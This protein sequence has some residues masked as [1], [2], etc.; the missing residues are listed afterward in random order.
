[1]TTLQE[2]LEDTKNAI[3][4]HAIAMVISALSNLAI[5][6]LLVQH[7]KDKRFRHTPL[8][9]LSI[10]SVFLSIC[11]ALFQSF[12]LNNALFVLLNPP[13][14]FTHPIDNHCPSLAISVVLPLL[15]MYSKWIFQLYK[16]YVFFR[17]TPF[18]LS[19]IAFYSQGILFTVIVTICYY[20]L[21]ME[22]NVE[23]DL[24][25]AVD[26]AEYKL[27][28]ITPPQGT[29]ANINTFVSFA[30][31]SF[32]QIFLLYLLYSKARQLEIYQ[33][34]NIELS[35]FFS[36]AD[37]DLVDLRIIKQCLYG[38]V[39]VLFMGYVFCFSYAHYGIKYLLSLAPGE[40][41]AL[42]VICSFDI[43]FHFCGRTSDE[44]TIQARNETIQMQ[45]RQE[46]LRRIM[47]EYY[48]IPERR[49]TR[50][51]MIAINSSEATIN[52][53]VAIA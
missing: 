18:K 51:E 45:R 25:V 17:L 8:K 12:V 50:Q 30:Y 2:E 16:I 46:Y 36:R 24:Y 42:S 27:C 39:I 19:S 44:D 26:N 14:S 33:Q 28:F 3:I 38:S 34:N 52:P 40:C 41:P 11:A 31:T 4:S 20:Q 13:D 5:L 37:K 6:V 29:I 9:I 10:F 15:S 43:E 23:L 32:I 53:C 22:I 7:F 49:V 48:R 1:M 21:L 47:D 35:P